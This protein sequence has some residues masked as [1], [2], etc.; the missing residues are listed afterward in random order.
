MKT[1]IALTLSIALT[2]C[3]SVDSSESKPIAEIPKS[4]P[5]IAAFDVY[6][7][8]EQ[9]GFSIDKKFNGKNCSFTCNQV[10]GDKVYTV[11]VFGPEPEAIDKVKA[12][13]IF[14]KADQEAVSFLGQAASLA[15]QGSVPSAASYWTAGHF[16]NGGDTTIGN[17]RFV[18]TA[19]SATAR[20]LALYPQ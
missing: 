12:T 6:G 7:S 16:K 17:V 18:L 14:K 8:F 13:V 3:F 4:I 10:L 11:D 15:Y 20:V 19:E 1:F 2:G 5:G 9:Q